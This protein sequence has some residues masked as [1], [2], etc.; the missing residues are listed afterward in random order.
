MN[1]K[2]FPIFILLLIIMVVPAHAVHAS[3]FGAKKDNGFCK[4]LPV[5]EA[6]LWAKVNARSAKRSTI[7]ANHIKELGTTWQTND[8]KITATRADLDAKRATQFETLYTKADTDTKKQAVATLQQSIMTATNAYRTSVDSALSL[9]KKSM[10]A[11]LEKKESPG[12]LGQAIS[13][14][15]SACA[16]GRSDT[17][18]KSEFTKD[19][20]AIVRVRISKKIPEA[21]VTQINQ[22]RATRE[23]SIADAAIVYKKALALAK[24]QFDRSF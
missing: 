23:Q 9:A 20:T 19:V 2:H 12:D 13:R 11:T 7:I 17:D 6:K 22:I 14:A 5:T 1:Y 16:I 15:R 24:D 8:A 3:L 21:I 18:T 4:T 10:Q